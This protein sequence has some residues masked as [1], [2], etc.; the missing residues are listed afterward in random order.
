M[1]KLGFFS[2]L[3]KA[4]GGKKSPAAGDPLA[5]IGKLEELINEN[6]NNF[7]NR[8]KLA[9][10]YLAQGEKQTALETFFSCARLY[11]EHDFIP[12][13]IA[14]YKKILAEEPGYLEA[15]L[16]LARIYQQK[17]L[18]ADA[19]DF[20]LKAF[21]HLRERERLD[22][23]LQVLETLIGIAPD[24][25]P[26][27]ILLKELFPEY[28]E[29]E[30]SVYSDIIITKSVPGS[31]KTGEP[32]ENDGFFDLGAE[33]GQQMENIEFSESDSSENHGD[34]GVEEIFQTLKSDYGRQGNGLDN[35]KFHYNLALAY[36]ELK[37]QDQ[38]LQE[39]EV[40]LKSPNF[41]LPSLLLR[42]R[43]FVERQAYSKA[44]SQIQQG[45]REKGLTRND[46]LTLKIQLGLILKEMGH[47]S[48]A[49][50]AFQEALSIEPDNPEVAAEIKILEESAT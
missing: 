34:H 21:N 41:R 44:L 8:L 48:K 38:A 36:N 39:S 45:L 16:E 49:L 33:L 19:A 17:K 47:N 42:S 5:E 25:E 43:I 30:K 26:Y 10:L 14:T 18:N 15:N 2:K 22:E 4:L 37:M 24:K 11:Q 1:T 7:R 35:D 29:T 12:L 32:P 46:F 31:E 9:D 23:A 40:A 28:R 6:P 27:R 50:E 3:K 20:Y 13:A